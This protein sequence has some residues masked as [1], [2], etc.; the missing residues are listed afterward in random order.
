[1][2]LKMPLFM[3]RDGDMK[4]KKR[5][6]FFPRNLS[7]ILMLFAVLIFA[8]PARADSKIRPDKISIHTMRQFGDLER[9]EVPF[10][11]DAHT[12]A[13]EK[14]DKDC[15]FCH[16]SE[17]NRLSLKFK[18]ILDSDQKALK[19][20]YHGNCISCHREMLAKK[21]K[22]GPVTCGECHVKTDDV[23]QDAD[24]MGFDPSLHFRHQKAAE[25][26]CE[27]CHHEYDASAKKKVY[28]KG[29]E[30]TCRYCHKADDEE[31]RISFQKAAHQSCIACHLDRIK[32]SLAAG[33]IYCYGCHDREEKSKIKIVENVPRVDRKQPDVLFVS[34]FSP[35]KNAD[36]QSP[37]P[38]EGFEYRMK[39]VPFNHKGHESYN[40]TCRECHHAALSPCSDC[41]TVK[42]SK[43]GRF[44][45]LEQ[46]M[47]QT[48]DSEACIG[49]HNQKKKD[50]DCMGCH[51]KIKKDQE[52]NQER[53]KTCH[54][55][56]IPEL[57]FRAAGMSG[58]KQAEDLLKDLE[59]SKKDVPLS[60]IPETVVIKSLEN[61][62]E[63]VKL[64]HGKIV[65]A[66]LQKINKNRLAG[67]FHKGSAT[68]CKGC[69]H[70]SPEIDKPPKCESCH[71]KPFME[72]KMHVPGLMGA[73][74][75]Q[76]MECHEA[77][78]IE[79]PKSTDCTGCHREKTDRP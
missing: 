45:P 29:K 18:R 25:N 12:R 16:L 75:R 64:P 79:K 63:P 50:P 40:T 22:T 20:V 32:S 26:Q 44:I 31:N 72:E 78:G 74:H 33:P 6:L 56:S 4:S 43:S 62:Y 23:I 36:G 19:E 58:S 61:Q 71:G 46:A 60:A 42:G 3:L 38:L 52:G 7:T 77:M 55:G 5:N 67:V 15:T 17:N 27:K 57:P 49:C 51:G 59:T 2:T 11:H 54:L 10:L 68:A 73:Y 47:H 14:Q 35:N 65:N 21:E 37:Q 48:K 13:L 24:P 70:N 9:P 34:R 76:C 53:C 30:G 8:D 1:M 41:H 28:A 39:L 69:H 66:L